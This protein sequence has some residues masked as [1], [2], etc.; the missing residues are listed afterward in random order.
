MFNR[1][2]YFRQDVFLQT[3]TPHNLKIAFVDLMSRFHTAIAIEA[4]LSLLLSLFP[5]SDSN[6]D[7]SLSI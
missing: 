7:V 2:S 5:L 4:P 6:S 3:V 1:I